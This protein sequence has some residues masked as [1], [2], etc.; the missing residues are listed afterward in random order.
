MGIF[1]FFFYFLTDLGHKQTKKKYPT[2]ISLI[3]KIFRSHNT[4]VHFSIIQVPEEVL[5][6]TTENAKSGRTI[7][8][9]SKAID[10]S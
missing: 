2:S 9:L 6:C 7:I 5:L 10:D 4:P 1:F 3:I 8:G